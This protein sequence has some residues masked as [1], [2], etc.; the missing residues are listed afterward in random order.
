[1]S[2]VLPFK[3]PPCRKCGCAVGHKHDHDML[4]PV[5]CAECLRIYFGSGMTIRPDIMRPS[6]RKRLAR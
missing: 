4:P 1:M 6:K 5:T 2:K 3:K